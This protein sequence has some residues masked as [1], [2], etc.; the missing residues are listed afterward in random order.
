MIENR[1]NKWETV[2][3]GWNCTFLKNHRSSVCLFCLFTLSFLHIIHIPKSH[4]SASL[5]FRILILTQVFTLNSHLSH[6]SYNFIAISFGKTFANDNIIWIIDKIYYGFWPALSIAMKK[7]ET[8]QHLNEERECRKRV[9][10]IF[11]RL[12]DVNF[13]KELLITILMFLKSLCTR[14]S[15]SNISLRVFDQENRIR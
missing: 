12:I 15:D 14:F 9:E 2:H 6:A 7:L 8:D 10:P 5:N 11:S 13:E 4:H 3:F 1:V